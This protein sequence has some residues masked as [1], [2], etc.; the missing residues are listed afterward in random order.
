MQRIELGTIG[1]LLCEQTRDPRERLGKVRRKA[2]TVGDLAANVAGDA[3]EK[4]LQPPDLMS[5]TPHLPRV[6][7]AIGQAQRALAQPMIA[8]SQLD[9][10]LCGKPHQDLSPAMVEARVG[11]ER[12]CLRLHRGID[13]HPLNA[14]RLHRTSIHC[15]IDG[16]GEQ[17]FHPARTDALAPAGQ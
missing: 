3:T 9:A 13:R 5:R 17:P 14:G 2:G 15:C 1:L 12:D 4:G 6:R 10:V 7:I 8:L 16:G 11:R